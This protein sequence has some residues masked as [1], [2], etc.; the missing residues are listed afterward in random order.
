ML[1]YVLM[2]TTSR[3][4]DPPIQAFQSFKYSDEAS[5]MAQYNKYMAYLGH[6]DGFGAVLLFQWEFSWK[7]KS[8]QAKLIRDDQ[9]PIL[10]KVYLNK[11][12]V[13]NNTF[14]SFLDQQ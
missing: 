12:V 5:A 1:S 2:A 14:K 3:E 8:F 11:N 6:E 9:A 10:K 7:T 13:Y 4:P